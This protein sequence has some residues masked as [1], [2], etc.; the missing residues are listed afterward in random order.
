MKPILEYIYR[1]KM[2]VKKDQLGNLL[3]VAEA[4]QVKALMKEDS[5]RNKNNS[6]WENRYDTIDMTTL[7]LD[8]SINN[9]GD[10]VPTRGRLFVF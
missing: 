4:Q 8:I 5:N 9:N 7:P 6:R 3:K 1:G 10:D 2:N